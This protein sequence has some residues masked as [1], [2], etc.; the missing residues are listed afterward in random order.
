MA[1]TTS[2][3]SAPGQYLM[4]GRVSRVPSAAD[5]LKHKLDPIVTPFPAE[6]RMSNGFTHWYHKNIQEKLAVI[7]G[8][9]SMAS[10]A[11]RD[12]KVAA[13]TEA[14]SSEAG[15]SDA[16]I[17]KH[18]DII[19]PYEPVQ[20]VFEE[21]LAA[22]VGAKTRDFYKAWEMVVSFDLP[23]NL[24]ANGASAFEKEMTKAC[25][26]MSKSTKAST[27]GGNLVV[28]NTKVDDTNEHPRPDGLEQ[29]TFLDLLES[30]HGALAAQ[31][32]GGA[33]VVRFHE[34]FTTPMVK[35]M[36]LLSSLYDDVYQF[37]PL[38]SRDMDSERFLVCKGYSKPKTSVDLAPAL[39]AATKGYVADL[40]PDYE[41]S[42]EM[43]AYVRATGVGFANNQFIQINEV[44]AYLRA[45][46]YFGTQYQE[47][48]KRQV[49]SHEQ[50]VGAFWSDEKMPAVKKAAASELERQMKAFRDFIAKSF[51]VIKFD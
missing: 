48:L 47:Y 11:P 40:F 23:T 49:T 5:I 10:K 37:K 26:H 29:D 28:A 27:K 24:T 45:G 4:P 22:A 32:T 13:S 14:L 8:K 21:T 50:W 16:A 6:P 17:A 3:Q 42:D 12:V 35:T 43:S 41:V 7:N 39:K 25:K 19:V 1:S 33:M 38:A 34:A 31:T 15:R 46:N 20:T 36:C 30:I 51:D 18:R 9:V 2:M 44:A